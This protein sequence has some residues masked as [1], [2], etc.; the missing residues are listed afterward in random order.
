MNIEEIIQII[1][2]YFFLS[3]VLS[4]KKDAISPSM[5]NPCELNI[6]R[7]TAFLSWFN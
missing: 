7:Y 6:Q 3:N 1:G 4:D 2:Y 5:K